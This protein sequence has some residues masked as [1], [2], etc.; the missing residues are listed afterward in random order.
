M[1]YKGQA[2]ARQTLTVTALSDVIDPS[3]NAVALR[4]EGQKSLKVEEAFEIQVRPLAN[5]FHVEE[6][7]PADRLLSAECEHLE[8][9]LKT[10]DCQTEV[11]L[12]GWAE[13]PLFSFYLRC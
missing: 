11:G 12:M 13:H 1:R 6:V 9:V 5:K 10:V 2:V 4:I 7:R 8:I 3:M